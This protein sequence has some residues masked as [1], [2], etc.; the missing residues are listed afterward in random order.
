MKKAGCLPLSGLIIAVSIAAVFGA[1]EWANVQG[2]AHYANGNPVVGAQVSLK[3]AN[4][5][6]TTDSSG[7]FRLSAYV[8]TSVPVQDKNA[9][10]KPVLKNNQLHLS[11]PVSQTRVKVELFDLGGKT[12]GTIVNERFASGEYYVPV[13]KLTLARQVYLL[14]VSIGASVDV[15]R[16]PIM[17]ASYSRQI[18]T[19]TEGNSKAVLWKKAALG[20]TVV[21]T[22]QDGATQKKV[23][24]TL[25]TTVLFTFDNPAGT[26]ADAA[27]SAMPMVMPL[28]QTSCFRYC[29]YNTIAKP[30]PYSP[31]FNPD[32][33]NYHASFDSTLV[34]GIKPVARSASA[35]VAVA[36]DNVPVSLT[37]WYNYSSMLNAF[38]TCTLSTANQTRTFTTTVTAGDNV[39]K[40][41][42][43]ISLTRP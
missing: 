26:G 33:L 15:F 43:T 30:I 4:L 2:A 41:T 12:C 42:Y 10:Y 24:D 31:A 8:G 18:C 13:T 32:S 34:I 22:A 7:L 35:K 11:I 38:Y 21:A 17:N 16:L 36:L 6:T 28:V 29:T 19:S 9:G 5:S 1:T 40:K 37:L 39:S 25:I 23:I 27:L 20:D 14:K 3:V